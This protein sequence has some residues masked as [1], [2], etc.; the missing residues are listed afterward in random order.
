MGQ[1]RALLFGLL[2]GLLAGCATGKP[3]RFISWFGQAP[4]QGLEGPDVI[5]MDVALIERPPD[6]AYLSWEVWRLADEQVVS[7]ERRAVLE[8]S[9]FRVGLLAGLKPAGLQTLL[10]SE[11]SCANPRRFFLHAGKAAT[12]ALGPTRARYRFQ[13]PEAGQAGFV[14]FEQATS[15]LEVVPSLKGNGQIQLRFTPQMQHGEPV[16]AAHTAEDNSGFLLQAERPTKSYAALAWEVTL[17]PNQYLIVG[18]RLDRP[19]SLGYQS[20]LRKDEAVAVQ[21]LLVIRVAHASPTG[22]Q[23][24]SVDSEETEAHLGRTLPLA[25]QAARGSAD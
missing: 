20:F 7:L 19:E 1:G 5:R 15:S 4:F 11:K 14:S 25:L 17:A 23:E 10:S 3:A 2:V 12:V 6:D 9:G 24:D 18:A 8:E 13:I 22:S 21:R 16:L